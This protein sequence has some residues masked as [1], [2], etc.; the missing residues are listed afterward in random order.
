[1]FRIHWYSTLIIETINT[2]KQN[3][4]KLEKQREGAIS[5]IINQIAELFNLKDQKDIDLSNKSNE[6]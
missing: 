1:M 2:I 5:N 4:S 6:D 3:K